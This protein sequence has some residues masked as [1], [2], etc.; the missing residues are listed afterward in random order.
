MSDTEGKDPQAQDVPEAEFHDDPFKSVGEEVNEGEDPFSSTAPPVETKKVEDEDEDSMPPVAPVAAPVKEPSSPVKSWGGFQE[1]R[2]LATSTSKVEKLELQFRVCEPKMTMPDSAMDLAYWIYHV[3]TKA[4]LAGWPESLRQPR[5]YSD[6][7]WLREELCS[8]FPGAIVPPLPEKNVKGQLEKIMLNNLELLSYRQRALTKFL[9][10]TGKHYLLKTSNHLKA[11]CE[12]EHAEWEAYKSATKKDHTDKGPSAVTSM[13]QKGK[14]GWF[15]MFK[16]KGNQEQ[17]HA[18]SAERAEEDRKLEERKQYVKE[19]EDVM[20]HSQEKLKKHIDIRFETAKAMNELSAFLAS[21]GD[22]ESKADTVLGNDLK[23][24]GIYTDQLSKLHHEQANKELV[25]VS[26]VMGYY[27]GLFCA[28]KEE[29][30]RLQRMQVTM[31]TNRD[32][33]ESCEAALRKASGEK[34]AKAESSRDAAQ[35]RFED[36]KKKLEAGQKLFETEWTA[37]HSQKQ[38]DFLA[39]QKTFVE[40]QISYGKQQENLEHHPIQPAIFTQD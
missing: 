35:S 13:V 24:S 32:D 5:R 8:Q 10:N 6:F 11:F 18:Q 7:L 30:R 17:V 34:R 14:E 37:F 23:N 19:M 16:K 28:V 2:V 4:S 12:L 36:N 26:E 31:Y 38:I 3:V 39:L 1:E 27:V 15:K 29:I 9:N 40:L 21:T 33:L 20:G 22:L 25:L